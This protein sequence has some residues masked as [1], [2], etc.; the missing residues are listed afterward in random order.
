MRSLPL[1]LLGF[2]AIPA[3]LGTLALRSAP[4]PPTVAVTAIDYALAAPDTLREG[5]VTFHLTNRGKEFHHLW[6]IRLEQGKTLEDFRAALAAGGAFPAWARSLGGPNAPAPQ[7]GEANA[8]LVLA[9][10][11]YLLVCGIPGPDG[12]PHLMKGMIRPLTV[13]AGPAAAAVPR[14]DITMSLRDYDFVLS[15]P[16]APGRRVIEVRNDGEQ[17]HEVE[18]VRLAPGKSVHDVLAWV[19]KP[20]GPPPGMPL[21]GVSPLGRGGVASFEAELAPGRYGLI[22]FLPDA[23]DG[24]PHHEHGMIQE[25]EVGAAGGELS[26][27]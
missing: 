10:G 6:V 15:G 9:A 26:A 25:F 17:T 4:V 11:R 3:V 12:V 22:C 20:A 18:L 13:V 19:E 5:A 7:G 21:G 27:R 8:T 2:A 24:K 16:A 14:P 1:T 23:R